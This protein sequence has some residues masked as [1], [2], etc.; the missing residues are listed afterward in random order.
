MGLRLTIKGSVISLKKFSVSSSQPPKPELA[1]VVDDKPP[2]LDCF[3]FL[4]HFEFLPISEFLPLSA[5][6]QNGADSG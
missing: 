6:R 2:L 1:A 5:R 4:R 3:A